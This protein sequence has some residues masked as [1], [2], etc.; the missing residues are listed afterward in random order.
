MHN[1]MIE[2]EKHEKT[3]DSETDNIFANRFKEIN[4]FLFK[5][6]FFIF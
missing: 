4:Q 6:I 1:S 2:I 3:F 5:V